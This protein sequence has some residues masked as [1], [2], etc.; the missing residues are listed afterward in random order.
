MLT[1]FQQNQDNSDAQYASFR[2]NIPYLAIL[3]VVHP[4]VRRVYQSY[5]SRAGTQTRNMNPST[6]G[7]VQLEQR[8]RFDFGFGLVF[9]TALHG[10]SAL[11]V[12][13]IL[14]INYRIGKSLP[15]QYVPAVTWT[16]NICILFANELCGG[17][18][19]EKVAMFLSPGSGTPGEKGSLLVRWAQMLD[20]FGGIM[21]RWE[22][23]FKVTVLRLISFNMDH[24]WSVDYPAASPI[25]VCFWMISLPLLSDS[26]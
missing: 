2:D 15:R 26:N 10:I 1:L 13:L 4:L 5:V 22:V 16:F 12:L 17:Y 8:M 9:I 6:A 19:L 3:L 18:P 23:L 21:P 14:F 20:S 7:D 24:Y 11:K 25:E